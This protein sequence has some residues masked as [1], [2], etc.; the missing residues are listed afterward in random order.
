MTTIFT[1]RALAFFNPQLKTFMTFNL[2][3]SGQKVEKIG[4]KKIEQY[5]SFIETYEKYRQES[6]WYTL[7]MLNPETGK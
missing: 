6:E 7:Y 4:M 2:Y 1:I 3:E 5:T